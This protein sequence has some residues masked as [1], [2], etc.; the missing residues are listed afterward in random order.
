MVHASIYSFNKYL[1]SIYYVPA[2]DLGAGGL[3]ARKTDRSLSS[4]SL[5]SSGGERQ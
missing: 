4:W 2:T 3:A 5:H 1:L